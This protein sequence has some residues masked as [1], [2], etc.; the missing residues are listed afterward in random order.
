MLSCFLLYM[1]KSVL[2]LLHETKRGVNV[3]TPK[4]HIRSD[5]KKSP[6][7]ASHALLSIKLSTKIAQSYNKFFTFSIWYH[8]VNPVVLAN[9]LYYSL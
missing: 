6:L 9:T 2:F 5:D 3:P 4:D 1:N 7:A 8:H